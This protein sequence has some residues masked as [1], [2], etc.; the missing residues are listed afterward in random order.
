MKL[1]SGVTFPHIQSSLGTTKKNNPT[2]TT[3]IADTFENLLKEVDQQQ[4]VAEEKQTELLTSPNKDLHG[5]I[6]AMEKAD[7][8]LRLLL[9]VK[10]KVTAAYEE[11]IRMQV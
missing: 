5:T 11:I 6:I 10:N 8:S 3:T 7:L 1:Q 2:E 9:Q 4:K